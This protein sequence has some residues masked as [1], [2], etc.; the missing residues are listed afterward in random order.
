MHNIC[1]ACLLLGDFLCLLIDA[2]MGLG[3]KKHLSWV[4]T[5]YHSNTEARLFRESVASV[6]ECRKEVDHI[7][8]QM[9]DIKFRRNICKFKI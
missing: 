4:Q 9:A 1:T 7:L 2:C 8:R 5:C 3:R 6:V